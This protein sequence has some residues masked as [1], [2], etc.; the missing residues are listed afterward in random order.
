MDEINTTKKETSKWELVTTGTQE[1]MSVLENDIKELINKPSQINNK[2]C[3][4]RL[5]QAKEASTL[6]YKCQSTY[7]LGIVLKKISIQ[8][9]DSP[10]KHKEELQKELKKLSNE[11]KETYKE[12]L[13]GCED[14]KVHTVKI[15]P[16]E[17]ASTD[18]NAEIGSLFKELM[19]EL[20]VNLE[21]NLTQP[22]IQL[23]YLIDKNEAVLGID[24]IGEELQKRPYKIF[25]QPSSLN[26]V[27]AYTILRFADVKKEDLFVDCFCGGGTIPIEFAY[28]KTGN[29]PFTYEHKFLG[30][31][32]DFTK[33]EFIKIKEELQKRLQEEKDFDKKNIWGFDSMF[34]AV[35]QAQKNA[36]IA[37]LLG[38][39]NFSKVS[40][41]WVDTKFEQ[42]EVDSIVSNIPKISKRLNNNKEIKKV[43]NELFYQARFMLKPKGL[44][45]IL[46]NDKESL[47][48]ASKKHKFNKVKEQEII[49]GEQKYLFVS[50]ESIKD[51]NEN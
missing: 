44:L 40:I 2:L 7:H 26:S 30:L 38:T 17:Y 24:L 1:L 25:S 6:A 34:N 43:I 28:Y 51:H 48:E 19:Q 45:S 39:I 15:T 10:E 11:E 37:G 22:N 4:T 41:D 9:N 8:E 46:S 3:Y 50:Y 12:L 5:C 13:K 31:K 42:G 23:I 35:S 27:F 47:E 33:K 29:S 16:Q 32:Y 14:F 49:Q 36:K 20:D 18:Y 21:V